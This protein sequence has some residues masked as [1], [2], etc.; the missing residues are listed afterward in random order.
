MLYFLRKLK[1][2]HLKRAVRNRCDPQVIYSPPTAKNR[3]PARGVFIR[4]VNERVA[5]LWPG[6]VVHGRRF[7][8]LCWLVDKVSNFLVG[9]VHVPDG[10]LSLI[11]R[12]KNMTY[13]MTKPCPICKRQ[14]TKQ[15][16]TD[17]VHCA[18]GKHV[19]QG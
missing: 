5:L 8:S 17:T 4:Q 15:G 9:G 19:W 14:L 10:R 16:P 1:D 12:G 2:I 11:V 6:K 18:C 7:R 3:P 13:V